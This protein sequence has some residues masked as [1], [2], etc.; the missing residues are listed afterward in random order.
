MLAVCLLACSVHLGRAP[1]GAGSLGDVR[2]PVA[3]VG[4][5]GHLE[6]AL[7]DVSGQLEF[8]PAID[9]VVLDSGVVPVAAGGAAMEARLHLQLSQASE[10]VSVSGSQ[11]FEAPDP[12]SAEAGRRQAFAELSR[13]LVEDGVTLLLGER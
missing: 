5:E 8:G 3:E 12:L 10:S 9:V 11:V 6:T 7:S 13:T 2:A 1:I 4:L